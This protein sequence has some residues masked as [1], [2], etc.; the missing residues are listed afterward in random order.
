[1]FREIQPVSLLRVLTARTKAY[2]V[3]TYVLAKWV[4]W[5]VPSFENIDAT[6]QNLLLWICFDLKKGT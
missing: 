4:L 6:E 5:S 1:M 2:Y 3:L